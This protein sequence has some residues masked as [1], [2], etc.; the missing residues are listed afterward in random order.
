MLRRLSLAVVAA[1][2][3]LTPA[4]A[5][6][7]A[8][9]T[10]EGFTVR[11]VDLNRSDGITP[12]IVLAAGG[13]G[14]LASVSVFDPAVGMT[15]ETRWS[16][17]PWGPVSASAHLGRSQAAAS[18]E[19]DVFATNGVL[20][21]S[22][23][24]LGTDWPGNASSF[25]ARAEAPPTFASFTLS[26]YTL[27][28]FSGTASL[29][30]QTTVGYD[31]VSGGFETA[32]A[33]VQLS[34]QGPAPGGGGNQWASD[35]RA[36]YASWAMEWDPITGDFA[37]RGTSESIGGQWLAVSFTN[38]TVDEMSGG[39]QIMLGAEGSSAV[40]PVPELEI[41]ALMLAGLGTIGWVARRRQH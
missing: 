24:A 27:A 30:A 1:T 32:S 37:Y 4:F 29:M 36:V 17:D 40:N 12:W 3:P 22:G 6:S 25:Q 9:A 21:A 18:M 14:S 5:D 33:S 41:W 20:A 38:Y 7:S 13:Y 16:L 34:A 8:S 19:G 31:P 15:S 11:L 28:L 2:L 10:L 39:L 23:A 35:G 26:P